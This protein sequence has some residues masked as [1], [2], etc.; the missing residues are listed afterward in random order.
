M[1]AHLWDRG[2]KLTRVYDGEQHHRST[3]AKDAMEVVFNLDQAWLYFAPIE[4][5]NLPTVNAPRDPRE[6]Y[7][8]LVLG[9]GEDVIS[10]WS[11][12]ERDEDGFNKSMDEFTDDASLER[13]K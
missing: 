3:D 2:F 4:A 12:S 8:M 9:N 1:I 11:Y 5:T 7:V 6:H 13:F 10:D